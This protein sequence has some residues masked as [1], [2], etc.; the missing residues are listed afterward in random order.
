MKTTV[1]NLYLLV[2]KS[3]KCF[4]IYQL[5]GRLWIPPTV[6]PDETNVQ[7]KCSIPQDIPWQDIF[8]FLVQLTTHY[9]ETQSRRDNP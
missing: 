7:N 9:T 1:Q 4:F 8:S 6:Q 5:R 2:R 3:F